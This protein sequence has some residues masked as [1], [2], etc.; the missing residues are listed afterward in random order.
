[1][2]IHVDQPTWSVR[3]RPLTLAIN[4]LLRG[5]GVDLYG[6]SSNLILICQVS[7]SKIYVRLLEALYI[8]VS[9]LPQ[10]CG[11]K[12]GPPTPTAKLDRRS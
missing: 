8:D 1:M 7:K 9:I 12:V 3:T 2:D 5:G 6:K 10:N 11:A 4:E